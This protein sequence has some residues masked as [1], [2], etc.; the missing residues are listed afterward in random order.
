M[1]IEKKSLNEALFREVADPKTSV[2]EVRTLIGVGANVN[3]AD[4]DGK[5]AL[6]WA[7]R[8]GNVDMVKLLLK[9]G[10]NV[11]AA[12]KERQPSRVPHAPPT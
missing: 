9:A 10:A 3:A 7:V 5:T 1:M 6:M 8:W 2:E 11:H 4:G 12:D